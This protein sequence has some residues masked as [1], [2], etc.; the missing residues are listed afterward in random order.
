MRLPVENAIAIVRLF[1]EGCSVRSI[2]RVTGVHRDTI[3]R[4][5]VLAGERCERLLADTITN[6]QVRDVECDEMWG[7][8]GMKEKAKG[9]LYKHL[10]CN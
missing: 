9:N 6:L 5:L 2:E 8:V 4:L 3:L 7:F 1:V 10:R